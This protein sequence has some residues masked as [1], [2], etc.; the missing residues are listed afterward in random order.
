MSGRD[1]IWIWDCDTK[2]KGELVSRI[3]M[4]NFLCAVRVGVAVFVCRG[5][6]VHSL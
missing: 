5:L 6:I 1:R 4:G 2:K 3:S